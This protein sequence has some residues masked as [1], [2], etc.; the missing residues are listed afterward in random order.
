VSLT[1]LQHRSID[2]YRFQLDAL[3]GNSSRILGLKICYWR[4]K[5]KLKNNDNNVTFDVNTENYVRYTDRMKGEVK[6]SMKRINT[7]VEFALLPFILEDFSL[8]ATSQLVNLQKSF[9]TV[10]NKWGETAHKKV[11]IAKKSLGCVM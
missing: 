6:D 2:N 3:L 9:C 10:A 4:D 1:E 11:E 5:Q 8:L 7:F